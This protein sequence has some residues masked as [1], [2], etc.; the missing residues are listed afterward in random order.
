MRRGNRRKDGKVT[1][2]REGKRK[3]IDPDRIDP[4]HRFDRLGLYDRSPSPSMTARQCSGA[5]RTPP[6][7]LPSR[8]MPRSIEAKPDAVTVELADK[9]QLTLPSGDPMLRRLDLGYALNAHMAQGMTKA[10]AIEVISSTQRNLATQRTQNVLNTRATDD[11]HVVTNDLEALKFQLD[12]TPGNKTS[13]LEVLARSKS[14]P[15]GEPDRNPPASRTQDEPGAQGQARC[16]AGSGARGAGAATPRSRK[17]A[18]A[19]P[20]R[21]LPIPAFTKERATRLFDGCQAALIWLAVLAFAA[22]GSDVQEVAVWA[23]VAVAL[24]AAFVALCPTLPDGL[25]EIAASNPAP[26]SAPGRCQSRRG[27]DGCPMTI[28]K[29]ATLPTNATPRTGRNETTS[30]SATSTT[31]VAAVGALP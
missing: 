31:A 7:T 22:P 26:A 24:A 18:G 25:A 28:R 9:R 6:A 11:M 10:Q 4:Q 20:V 2:E 12:R 16:G 15:A 13:A 30:M 3:V 23:M 29:S 5:T 27:P 17:I 19:R 1:L 21:R 8:P 14:I